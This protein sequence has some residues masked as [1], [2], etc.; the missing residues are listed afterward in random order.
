MTTRS[1]ETLEEWKE[2]FFESLRRVFCIF[3]CLNY[4]ANTDML[5]YIELVLLR[6]DSVD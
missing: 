6:Y 4:G 2:T 1:I 5:I 3:S